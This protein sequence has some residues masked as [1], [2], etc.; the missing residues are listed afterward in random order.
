[1]FS[2]LADELRSGDLSISGSEEFGDFRAQL[3]PWQEC[4]ALLPGYCDKIGLPPTATE[5]VSGLRE[6]LTDTAQA[7]DKKFP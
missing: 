7:L 2:Y 4:V 6:W 5:F 1:M 3:L